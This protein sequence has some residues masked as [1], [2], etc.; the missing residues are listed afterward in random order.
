MFRRKWFIRRP[1]QYLFRPDFRTRT[2]A[3]RVQKIGRTFLPSSIAAGSSYV[4]TITLAFLA[5]VRTVHC[6]PCLGRASVTV[7]DSLVGYHRRGASTSRLHEGSGGVDGLRCQHRPR[8]DLAPVRIIAPTTSGGL[9]GWPSLRVG[10]CG[11]S[12]RI[13]FG[14]LLPTFSSMDASGVSL[15]DSSLI[16]TYG[17]YP[18]EEQSLLGAERARPTC[19]AARRNCS[20]FLAG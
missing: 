10:Q 2:W 18:S 13:I 3:S 9:G 12:L 8:I 11:G 19:S 20:S 14:D 1:A 15:C 5:T 7:K 16:H 6:I 17:G 4:T